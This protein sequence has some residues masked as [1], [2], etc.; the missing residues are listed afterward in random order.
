[1]SHRDSDRFDS[2][3][4]ET[5]VAAVFIE[6]L[7]RIKYIIFRVNKAL[8]TLISSD[9]LLS[10]QFFHE[11]EELVVWPVLLAI[12]VITG[13]NLDKTVL[14]LGKGTYIKEEDVLLDW[15]VAV[16]MRYLDLE[17]ELVADMI[18]N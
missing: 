15:L 1:M 4:V 13:S 12:L 10:H 8:Y 2:S 14:Y 5:L 16:A 7:Y 3:K 9:I 11:E 17:L 18:L 6:V